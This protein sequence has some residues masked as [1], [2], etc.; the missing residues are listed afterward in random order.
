MESAIRDHSLWANATDQEIDHAL[1]MLKNAGFSHVI[2]EDRTDQVYL[3]KQMRWLDFVKL[4]F[5]TD[6]SLACIEL[7][8]TVIRRSA[9]WR[10]NVKQNL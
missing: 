3:S 5:Y 10:K 4:A 6:T 8:I 2:A 9:S 7:V 1:E